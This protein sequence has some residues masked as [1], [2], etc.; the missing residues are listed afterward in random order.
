MTANPASA[1][2]HGPALDKRKPRRSDRAE[3]TGGN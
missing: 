1:R 2:P 3:P